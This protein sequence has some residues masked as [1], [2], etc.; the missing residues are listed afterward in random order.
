[1]REHID[2]AALRNMVL[3]AYDALEANE[4]AINELNVF[5]VPDGDTG[6][7]MRL[8]LGSAAADLRRKEATTVTA[9]ADRVASALL[10]G[11]RGNS[12]VI[13][14]LLFRGLSKGLKK[15]ETATAAE[16]ARAMTTGVESAYKAVMKP[17]E[18]TILT[19]SRM[20]A[21]AA[22]AKAKESENFEE[23]LY[24]AVEG[25]KT[26]LDGTVNQNP[27]L[28]KA[29]V[30]DAGGYGYVLM[31][32]AMLGYLE[33]RV[34]VNQNPGSGAAKAK[35]D[36]TAFATEDI[37]Y[38]Y[39]TEF[40][41]RKSGTAKSPDLLWAY[42][43]NIGDS[44]VMVDD[45]EIIKVHVH[46]NAPGWVLTQALTYGPLLT[47]KI[48]NMREQHTSLEAQAQEEAS[49]STEAPAEP[50][51]QPIPKP[52]PA[53]KPIGTVCVCAGDGLEE[54]FR[55]LGADGIVS[56][57]QTMNP[58]TEDILRAVNLT[59]AETV[60]VFPNNKNIIMAA[61]QCAPL[62][63]KKVI[64]IPSRTVPQGISAMMRL[65]P[66]ST[67][68]QL[69]AE[70]TDAISTVHTI[71]VT[72]AA[73]DSEFDGHAIR[74]GE[75]LTLMDGALVGSFASTD[76]LVSSLGPTISPLEPEFVTVYY[77]QDV[78]ENDAESFS[79]AL[80]NSFPDTETCL[81]RGGQPVYYYM[82][83]VE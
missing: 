80:G 75:F 65:S 36:F 61:E 15:L 35:A 51:N 38:T 64:V 21:E 46:T 77:G 28:K 31:L 24:A 82:I 18:G 6:A 56:G 30:I 23:M 41:V 10:R 44:I 50:E 11:A 74:A 22:N 62:T 78:A 49:A 73:R 8:T 55:Q 27:V 40:I 81:I 71:Q 57:G 20:A 45:A 60:F 53:E 83:S 58:S 68:E 7:N 13:L 47:T 19:V 48:E 69:Q 42:L 54:L 26:A 52:V 70:F 66:D 34:T 25:A 67:P 33:G 37:K 79:S 72:Y 17:A 76:E 63:P 3:C 39:C 4:Q 2:G 16:Y 1:M 5:P 12:G 32:E 29:G 9:T 43:E 14:S 59:P